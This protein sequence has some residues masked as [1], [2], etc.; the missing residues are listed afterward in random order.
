MWESSP[1]TQSKHD[2]EIR[3]I[4]KWGFNQCSY[5]TDGEAHLGQ[6]Q[7]AI[8]LLARSSFPWFLLGGVLRGN[9]L[10]RKPPT[11]PMPTYVCLEQMYIP[12]G[13]AETFSPSS[14]Y[15]MVHAHCKAPRNKSAKRFGTPLCVGGGGGL[16]IF[17]VGCKLTVNWTAQLLFSIPEKWILSLTC[18]I[19]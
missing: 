11:S 1:L 19:N 2:V 7:Q 6:S 12:W 13:N 4:V 10:P 16:Y 3:S 15:S 14:P 18:H 17:L 9:S 5:K 8:Y